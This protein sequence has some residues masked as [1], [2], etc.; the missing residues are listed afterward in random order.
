[1]KG[2]YNDYFDTAKQNYANVLGS[3]NKLTGYLDQKL[4]QGGIGD[5]SYF[6]QAWD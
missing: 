2:R 5:T 3:T 6:K 4:Q 1:M